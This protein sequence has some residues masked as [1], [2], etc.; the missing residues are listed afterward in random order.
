MLEKIIYL[1]KFIENINKIIE[2][3]RNS[4]KRING[5]ENFINDK[6]LY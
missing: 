4:L 6:S 2:F 5:K 1:T 3:N